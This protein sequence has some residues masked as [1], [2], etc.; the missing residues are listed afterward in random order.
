MIYCIEGLP[1][2]GKT[3]TINKLDI[4][5][6]KKYPERITPFLR[7]AMDSQYEGQNVLAT[8]V[9]FAIEKM[10]STP[11]KS[12]IAPSFPYVMERCLP[13]E[14]YVF[15]ET[16]NNGLSPIEY[17]TFVELCTYFQSMRDVWPDIIFYLDADNET[18]INRIAS[19][20]GRHSREFWNDKLNT[21]RDHYAK[22]LTLAER[23]GVVVYR[24]EP[25]VVN[26]EQIIQSVID[27]YKINPMEV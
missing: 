12:S 3:T 21:M 17:W 23:K 26:P 25:G 2:T 6:D 18:I 16:I 4:D 5:G 10:K 15:L 19:R 1:C 22:F 20:D 9:L 11:V 8:F 7:K 13:T 24:L 14:L 27:A